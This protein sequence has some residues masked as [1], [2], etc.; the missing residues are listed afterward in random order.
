LKLISSLLLITSVLMVVLL[1]PAPDP[2][3]VAEASVVPLVQAL[4]EPELEQPGVEQLRDLQVLPGAEVA[5]LEDEVPAVN[6]PTADQAGVTDAQRLNFLLESHGW[7]H[8]IA[9][10]AP[11]ETRARAERDYA[12][13]CVVTILHGRG[14]AV[15]ADQDG[16][17]R[18]GFSLRATHPDEYVFAADRARFTFSK[19][20]FPVFDVVAERFEAARQGIAVEPRSIELETDLEQL[21]QSALDSLDV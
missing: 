14:R 16:L 4:I 2:G 18:G 12:S 7:L 21:F 3:A 10:T 8:S 11:L 17:D 6:A 13:R 19:G 1:E 5:R 15:F 20:E 9:P